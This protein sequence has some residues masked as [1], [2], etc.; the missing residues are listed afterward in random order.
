MIYEEA[1]NITKRELL[2]LK[3]YPS[4]EVFKEKI[5]RFP[6]KKIQSEHEELFA[7]DGLRS[8]VKGYSIMYLVIFLNRNDHIMNKIIMISIQKLN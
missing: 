1:W 2:I 5:S 7:K 8:F 3:Y 6:N 4:F